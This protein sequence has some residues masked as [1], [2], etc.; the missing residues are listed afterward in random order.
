MRKKIK[1]LEC[2]RQGKIGGGESHLLSLMESI[3]RDIIDPVVLS[4]TD[5]PMIDRLKELNVPTHIIHT[6]RPFDFTK[7]KT[8]KNFLADQQIELIHAHGTRA[9][10]N[11]LV[12]AR[13]LGIPLI[14]TI[15]GWSFH[16]DQN[17]IVRKLRI[18]GEKYLVTRSAMNIS[19]AVS[20]QESGQKV[21]KSFQ[22]VVINN[23]I[24][25][26]KFD[27]AKQYPDIR[28]ELG[29]P[30]EDILIVFI[31]RFTLHKQP[32]ILLKA[33]RQLAE[34]SANVHLLMVG[35]GDQYQEARNMT[36]QWK[37]KSRISFQ[38]F[39]Q[40]VP[41]V[42]A[43]SDIFVLPSLWEGLPIGLLEAMSMGK[44]IVATNVDGSREII[45]NGENGLLVEAGNPEL[46][47]ESLKT[48]VQD[49]FLRK[50]IGKKALQTATE[51]YDA[52]V[53][54]NAIEKCY[55]DVNNRAS[56]ILVDSL[57]AMVS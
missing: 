3:N 29:I 5:G 14:Y 41:A 33:F 13:K 10:S 1:V 38:P 32:L 39:R 26:K 8:I 17:P 15:H 20:N 50:K 6:E 21:I 37:E 25:R 45:K 47:F 34:S 44:A 56:K 35:E 18:A 16:P 22:S 46:L 27:P 7:W 49:P 55:L 48:L 52:N 51:G 2:I 12:P 57:P 36:D 11:T 54:T 42:L 40:D 23:G 9:A 4:F 31:A 28:S 53:M 24:D 19:V 30:A 43:A